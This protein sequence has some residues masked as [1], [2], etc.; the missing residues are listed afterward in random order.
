VIYH[1]FHAG[2]VAYH[3]VQQLAATAECKFVVPQFVS[4]SPH[5]MSH[6]QISQFVSLFNGI[7]STA[8]F[9]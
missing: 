8:L 4:I 3:C 6:G 7:L 2:T 9:I 5:T 1:L